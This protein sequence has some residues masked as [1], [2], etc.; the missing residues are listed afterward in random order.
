MLKSVIAKIVN[1]IMAGIL[2]SIGG[3]VYLCC[4]N[5]YVGAVFFSV[6]L[7][8]I[9]YLEYS[10][11][12]GK[13]GFI[14]EKHGKEEFS[15]LLLGLLGN[16]IGTFLFGL[17]IKYAIGG[18]GDKALLICSKKL[19][20]NNFATTLIKGVMCGILMYIAVYVFKAH[21]KN[22]L[23]IIFGIPT[24]ILCGFEH[25]IADMFYFAVSGIFSFDAFLFLMTVV[26]GNAIGGMLLPTL[27]LITTSK[28]P[29][30][31]EEKPMV[32]ENEEN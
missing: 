4:E 27:R 9:C 18:V 11:F 10:L 3:T 32:E 5:N 12:T 21:N 17:L 15:V 26:L 7:L 23:G 8:S 31:T 20:V 22:P 2:I 14:P 1:G 13:I 6:A 16:L 28:K 29:Q 19:E 25:S 30:T 24:F